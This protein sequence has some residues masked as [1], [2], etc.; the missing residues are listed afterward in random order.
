VQAQ[1]GADAADDAT[2]AAW[3]NCSPDTVHRHAGK[4][5]AASILARRKATPSE[6]GG[7]PKT[8]YGVTGGVS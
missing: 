4:M 8:V 1:L 5:A 6:R 2:I 7:R 3:L